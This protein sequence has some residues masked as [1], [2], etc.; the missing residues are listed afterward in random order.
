MFYEREV[1][2]VHIIGC[3]WGRG[4]LA[5]GQLGRHLAWVVVVG[6]EAA[7]LAGAAAVAAAGRADPSAWRLPEEEKKNLT[8]LNCDIHKKFSVLKRAIQPL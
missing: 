6:Q 5:A 1:V 8:R 7:G 3:C 2:A 4:G